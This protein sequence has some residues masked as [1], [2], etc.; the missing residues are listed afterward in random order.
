MSRICPITRKVLL[1]LAAMNQY[2]IPVFHFKIHVQ[3]QIRR[4]T[5]LKY[6]SCL[7][8]GSYHNFVNLHQGCGVGNPVIRLRLLEI[9]IIG[10]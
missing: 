2:F 8:P 5:V 10:L 7:N 3:I 1:Y 9:S 4:Q 6:K